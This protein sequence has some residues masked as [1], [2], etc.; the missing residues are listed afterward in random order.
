[1]IIRL[2]TE[3]RFKRENYV[4]ELINFKHFRKTKASKT[5]RRQMYRMDNVVSVIIQ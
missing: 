4:K 5:L 2:L 1:M 3:T